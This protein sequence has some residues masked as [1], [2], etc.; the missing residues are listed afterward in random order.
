METLAPASAVPQRPYFSE[1][2]QRLMEFNSDTVGYLDIA[3]TVIQYP[4]V[5]GKDNEYYVKHTFKK[6]KNASGAI[7]M[8]C[9]NAK[10][11]SDFN[12]VIYGH[13]MKDG[14]M[15]HEL[16]QYQKTSFLRDHRYIT[17][18]GLYE[19]KKYYVFA[20]YTSK[21]EV[22]VRGF[23]CNTERERQAFLNGVLA[24]SEIS[25]GMAAPTANDQFLTLVTCRENAAGDYFVV[26]AILVE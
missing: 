14:S 25:A 26:H 19:Q 24:R 21:K 7:F 10:D 22:D 16:L 23:G 12:I 20:M 5:R 3:G 4:V 9:S 1:E 8:D 18:T 2:I 6:K 11:A 13:N 17:L 15:F